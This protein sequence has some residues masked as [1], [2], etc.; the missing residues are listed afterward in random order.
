MG[1]VRGYDGAK[2]VNGR[3]RHILVDSGGLVLRAKVHTADVQDRAGVP[4]LLEGAEEQ[5]RISAGE[6]LL[7][8]Q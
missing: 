6:V 8:N 5:H 3:K 4:L 7:M 2:R 1:G